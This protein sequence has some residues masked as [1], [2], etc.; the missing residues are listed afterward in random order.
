V[1]PAEHGEDATVTFEDAGRTGQPC[2]RKQRGLDAGPA[3]R[4]RVQAFHLSASPVVLHRSTGIARGD[5]ER[6]RELGSAE[7]KQTTGCRSGP[8]HPKHLRPMPARGKHAPARDRPEQAHDLN[9]GYHGNKEVTAAGPLSL[10]KGQRCRHDGGR[11]VPGGHVRVVELGAV[12]ERSIDPRCLRCAD[13]TTQHRRSL[14]LAPERRGHRPRWLHIRQP[15][16]ADLDPKVVEN[17]QCS[18]LHHLAG[19]LLE[20]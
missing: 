2:V 8:E 1:R 14:G 3:R 9:A 16:A 12:A 17:E 19:Q 4:T 6:M 11:G 5:P 20:P 15:R 10:G 7:A 13:T 18:E